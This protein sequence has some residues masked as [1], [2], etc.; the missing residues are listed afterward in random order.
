MQ[1]AAKSPADD[2]HAELD[3]NVQLDEEDN[4]LQI[5]DENQDL[6]QDQEDIQE[7]D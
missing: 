1:T 7:D 3:E 4:F 5:E 2:V 6:D